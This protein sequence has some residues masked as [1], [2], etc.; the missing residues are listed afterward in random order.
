MLTLVLLPPLQL[1]TEL[2]SFLCETC[3]S[4]CLKLNGVKESRFSSFTLDKYVYCIYMCI[5]SVYKESPFKR[6]T[7][8]NI[9]LAVHARFVIQFRSGIFLIKKI[10]LVLPLN[11]INAMN[12]ISAVL[13]SII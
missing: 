13:V 7:L 3:H 8:S 4:S 9:Y 1:K 10:D 2:T 12:Y 5:N 6:Q 11:D